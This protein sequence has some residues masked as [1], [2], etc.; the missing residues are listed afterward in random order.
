[1]VK[2][3]N[4]IVGARAGV[5]HRAFV[6]DGAIGDVLTTL[7]SV[8]AERASAVLLGLVVEEALLR[9]MLVGYLTLLRLEIVKI[10]ISDH[11]IIRG[12][13][14]IHILGRYL[15]LLN[16]LQLLKALIRPRSCEQSR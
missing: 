11:V 7:R 3:L 12:L 10:Q 1:M 8:G 2:L 5:S 9:I 6:V 14:L 15:L 13:E 16:L 4:S